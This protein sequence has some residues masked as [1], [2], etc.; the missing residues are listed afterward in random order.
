[1]S[2]VID[3]KKL[4]VRQQDGWCGPAVIQTVLVA[5]G[6]A[7]T[8]QEI[9][10]DVQLPW[11]G[12]ARDVMF[13]YF[14]RFFSS[15]FMKEQATIEDLAACLASRRVVVVEWWDD[16]ND[17]PNDPPDGHYSVVSSVNRNDGT[18]TLVDPS[19]RGIWEMGIADFEA[20]W[21]DYLDVNHQHRA[22]RWMLCVDLSS[23]KPDS[24]N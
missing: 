5:G 16:L 9:Y 24:A 22:E 2:P 21:Y 18:L 3:W 20:R 11:W 7:K 8:Q 6:I 17:D 1:M 23:K 15:V 12:T 14:S 13:A 19:Y 4:Y 10:R